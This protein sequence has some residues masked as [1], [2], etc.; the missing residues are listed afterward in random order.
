M[1]I[2]GKIQDNFE[3]KVES[4]LV[5]RDS[6]DIQIGTDWLLNISKDRWEAIADRVNKC[7]EF[8]KECEHENS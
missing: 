3:I 8:I 4:S 1:E 2:K 6:F 7:M 5:N